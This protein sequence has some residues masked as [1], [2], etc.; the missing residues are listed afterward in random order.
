MNEIMNDILNRYQIFLLVFIRATGI[1]IITPIFSRRNVPNILKI[2]FAFFIT[3]IVY[4]LLNLDIVIYDDLRMVGL[5]IQEFAIG[6]ILG[7]IAY[8]FFT[9][10]YVAGQIIDVQ[11]GFGMVN[12]LDP[13]HNVQLP[14]TGN[15][16][17]ILAVLIFLLVNGHHTI[18][19]A[20]V[21]SFQLIPI[22]EFTINVFVVNQMIDIFGQVFIIGIKIAIP[23][24]AT[25]FLANVLL[26]ILARTVPQM[27]VF[28]VGMPFKIIVGLLVL[29]FTLPIIVPVFEYIYDN[30]FTQIHTFMRLISR[31]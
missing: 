31:G 11:I 6:L 14:I 21:D 26:G 25:M 10:L 8:A 12:V 27:N 29:I 1:F 23:I 24:V 22:G 13:Q 20:L 30:I 7:F 28:V 18:I 15:F 4:N 19:T 3:L 9:S 17:Y 2:G 5:I 16:Y